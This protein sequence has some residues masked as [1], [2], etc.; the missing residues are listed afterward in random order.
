MCTQHHSSTA[1]E[2]WDG[3]SLEFTTSASAVAVEKMS[4][5]QTNDLLSPIWQTSDKMRD[6]RFQREDDEEEFCF[7]K[8]EK[9]YDNDNNEDRTV[10][11]KRA[12]TSKLSW[13]GMRQATSSVV[14]LRRFCVCQRTTKDVEK[15]PDRL[16]LW[17][18]K[19]YLSS[20]FD[21]SLEVV[22]C[23]VKLKLLV[24]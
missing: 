15:C 24:K 8:R 9:K 16:P 4:L 12:R 5:G 21:S 10:E 3:N 2:S 17:I 1:S 22:V 14:V 18:G 11:E 7:P 13:M 6:I 20:T 23:P 19:Q